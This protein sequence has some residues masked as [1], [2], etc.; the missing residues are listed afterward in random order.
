[1]LSAASPLSFVVL[2]EVQH[3]YIIQEPATAKYLAKCYSIRL[4]DTILV[5][6]QSVAMLVDA[7]LGHGCICNLV[8]AVYRDRLGTLL[9]LM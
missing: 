1:M 5:G 4:A 8:I 7:V 3:E 6:S 9:Y 2:R